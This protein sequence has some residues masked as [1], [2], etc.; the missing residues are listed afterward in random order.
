MRS[1]HNQRGFLAALAPFAPVI[2]AVAGGLLAKKGAEEQNI[3]S[4]AQSQ[5]QMDFQERMSNTAHQREV[6]DLRA[7]GLNPILS[8]TGGMGA[9]T[10]AGSAAPV[11]NELGAAVD[12]SAKSASAIQQQQYM[13]AQMDQLNAQTRLTSAQAQEAQART[14]FLTGQKYGDGLTLQQKGLEAEAFHRVAMEESQRWRTRLDRDEWHLLQENIANARHT[15]KNIIANTGNTNVDTAL[16]SIIEKQER[17]NLKYTEAHNVSGIA[18][19]A[20]GSALGLKNLMRSKPSL[21]NIRSPNII[22]NNR[23]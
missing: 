20:V 23:K 18:G 13:Q 4:A 3:A 14:D 2:G 16:K 6:A 7:A 8:G 9:S 19:E 21:S 1:L 22:I 5:A 15:G 10:P 12:A 11:V 17:I